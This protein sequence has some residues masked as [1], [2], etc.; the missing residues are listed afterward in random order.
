MA[1][2]CAER[3]QSGGATVNERQD[4]IGIVEDDL[5]TGRSLAALTSSLGCSPLLFR[6]AEEFLQCCDLRNVGCVLVDLRLPGI[7][8]LEL[9]QRLQQLAA[10]VPVILVS[11][12]ADVPVT[13]QAMRQGM[14]TVLEKPCDADVLGRCIREALELHH[15]HRSRNER[16]K[17]LKLRFDGLHPRER[18]TL[19]LIVAGEANKTIARRLGVSRRTVDRIRA[20]VLEKIGVES[21]FEAA[22]MLGEV[23][24]LLEASTASPS[25]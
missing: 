11:A 12:Y 2:R 15:R 14:L 13:V 21:A 17:Q 18:E 20:A 8:G 4:T 25:S 16:R 7:N 6:S 24:P 23:R 22:C 1:E 3:E 19:E 9:Q 10:D 5:A